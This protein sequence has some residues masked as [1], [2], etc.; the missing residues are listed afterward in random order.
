VKT[1]RIPSGMTEDSVQENQLDHQHGKHAIWVLP[2]VGI[3]LGIVMAIAVI[4][5]QSQASSGALPSPI[6]DRVV[7]GEL[8]P[9]FT[10]LTIDGA[11]ISLRD[12]R[13]SIVAVNFWATWC[14]PCRVEMPA[15]QA[16]Y[17]QGKLV[18]VAVNAGE[19]QPAI[20]AFMDELS[21]SFPALLD[22]DGTL[23]DL[24]AVRV[25]PTTVIV[26]PEGTVIAEH[27]GP[28]NQELIEQYIGVSQ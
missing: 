12:Y 18:V 2:L 5:P 9:E 24:Y 14:G 28:L 13:G 27:Y 23:V 3:G 11:T 7:E 21:L 17:D 16:A 25:F 19:S 26:S 20:T 10:A 1:K 22:E 6:P 8:A 4:A 15:L